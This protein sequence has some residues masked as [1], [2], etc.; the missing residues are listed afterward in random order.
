[1]ANFLKSLL[2]PQIKNL[3]IYEVLRDFRKGGLNPSNYEEFIETINSLPPIHLRTAEHLKIFEKLNLHDISDNDRQPITREL[4]KRIIEREKRCWHP[5]AG[6]T[7]CDVDSSGNIKI[8]AAHSLQNNGVLSKIA[9]NNGEVVMFD[10]EIP[11][12]IGKRVRKNSASTFFGFCNTHDAIF[13]PIEIVPHTK[14]IEQNFLFAYRAFIVAVHSKLVC[15]QF[16]DYGEQAKN[17]L[18]RNKEI[19]D[20]AI[21]TSDYSIIDTQVIEIEN[22]YP[23]ASASSF[24]LDFDFLGNHIPHSEYRIEGL[25]VTLFPSDK[26]TYFLMSYFKSDKEL[27]KNLGEQLKNRNK[28]KSDIS[29]LLMGHAENTYFNPIYFDTFIKKQADNIEKLV[30]DTQFELQGFDENGNLKAPYSF[31]PNSYL[32]NKYEIDL[33]GY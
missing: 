19:F 31:T 12:F 13:R 17:D 27:Y 21:L 22:F 33:F 32:S 16:I 23:I 7:T 14:T 26:S 3:I 25:F 15:S 9:D 1:M 6:E 11:E 30:R 2:N 18:I 8:T 20:K 28:L 5:S 4:Q 29:V 10:R 24:Y